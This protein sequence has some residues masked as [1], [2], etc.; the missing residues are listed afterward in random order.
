[1]AAKVILSF[2]NKVLGEYPLNKDRIVIG[3]KPTND[4]PVDNLA[5]SGAH[6]AIITILNDSFLEDLGST[7]GTF[8]NDKKIKKHA[9]QHGDIVKIGKHELK[10]VSDVAPAQDDFEKTMIMRPGVAPGPGKAPAPPTMQ[11]GLGSMPFQDEVKKENRDA[12]I[13][14]LTGPNAGKQMPLS[15]ALIKLGKP[16]VQLIVISRR[17]EG[18]FL[19]HIEGQRPTL[20]NGEGIGVKPHKLND[21]DVIEFSGIKLEFYF[22]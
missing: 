2:N 16:G 6:A 1:M 8:V 14:I 18:Y 22:I 3:R 21:H 11:P 20:V 9:L 10:Y 19:T 5:V 12:A 4:I 17:S 7:N 15:K 13:Q